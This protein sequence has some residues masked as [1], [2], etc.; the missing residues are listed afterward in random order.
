ML[1]TWLLSLHL[2]THV[3]L[4]VTVTR[5]TLS[6]LLRPEA[7]TQSVFKVYISRWVNS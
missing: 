1:K 7:D 5:E 4:S 2:A 3:E 6:L